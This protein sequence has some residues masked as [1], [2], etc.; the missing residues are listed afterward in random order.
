MAAWQ[1]QQSAANPPA[2]NKAAQV[3]ASVQN[4]EAAQITSAI[5][6]LATGSTFST[7]A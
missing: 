6:A 1:A 3:S 2:S 4:N 5:S 7:M